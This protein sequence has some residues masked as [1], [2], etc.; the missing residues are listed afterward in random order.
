MVGMIC[1]AIFMFGFAIGYAVGLI[2]TIHPFT[3]GILPIIQ[4]AAA[5]TNTIST[6]AL[7]FIPQ[8]AFVQTVPPIVAT[9][10][11]NSNASL[12]NMLIPVVISVVGIIAA[13][14]HS[15]KKVANIADVTRDN[16]SEIM[17]GK[18]V[19]KELASVSYKMNPVEAEKITDAPAVKIATLSNDV[20]DFATKAAKAKLPT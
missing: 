1:L 2:S 17:K 11:T 8:D 16:Q 13:K 4:P 12:T 19:D 3:F 14:F 18:V 7:R 5:Q 15:D 9:Q 6:P 10:Q 20:T